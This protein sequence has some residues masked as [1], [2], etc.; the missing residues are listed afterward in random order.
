MTLSIILR[1]TIQQY[2]STVVCICSELEIIWN[3]ATVAHCRIVHL[4]TCVT[5]SST[6]TFLAC[7]LV[8]PRSDLSRGNDPCESR[9]IITIQ[10]FIYML[11][12]QLQEPTTK[13]AQSD[14]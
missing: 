11:T 14:E 3:E 13:L 4:Y 12:Q 1:G 6:I 8:V 7:G 9:I 2:V 10:L 5:S